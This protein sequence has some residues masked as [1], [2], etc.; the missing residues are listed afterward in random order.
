MPA[1]NALKPYIAQGYYHIYNR[2]VEKRDIFLDEQ[3]YRVF[4]YYLKLYLLPKE[5][6]FEEIKHRKDLSMKDQNKRIAELFLMQNYYGK[7]RVLCYVLMKNHFHLLVRQNDKKDIESFMRSLITKYVKYFNRRYERVGPLFQSRYK[8]IIIQ[9][10]EYFLY[11]S[12]Y[13]HRNP[14]EILPKN[15]KLLEYQWS[16]YPAYVKRYRLDWL[17]KKT[18]LSYF[19]KTKGF[20]FS[21]YQGFVEGYKGKLED[22]LSELFLD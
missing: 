13:I 12:R 10:E 21:S 2:G 18:V 4:L 19:T 11:I 14:I 8:G 20:G 3:D 9:K 17:L 6:N 5:R 15:K 16:S 1:K 7:I 22:K